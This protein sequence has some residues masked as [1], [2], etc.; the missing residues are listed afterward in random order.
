MEALTL[1]NI[2]KLFLIA[3]CLLLFYFI[4]ILYGIKQ[5]TSKI[6]NISTLINHNSNN[7]NN[8]EILIGSNRIN[9]IDQY[10][11]H[12]IPT[13]EEE[14]YY[15]W[16]DY[17]SLEQ[18]TITIRHG[19]RSSIH[20]FPNNIIKVNSSMFKNKYFDDQALSFTSKLSQFQPVLID[21]ENR[22]EKVFIFFIY[23]ID[24]ILIFLCFNA[25]IYDKRINLI[26]LIIIII[27]IIIN[28]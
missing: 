21:K 11:T 3:N 20:S 13:G 22:I 6:R 18:L 23:F 7:N 4:H 9:R 17:F 26:I 8:D 14:T 5:N 27:I 24:F 19:D 16:K 25:L 15:S 12:T 10:C 28:T 1:Q 2:K